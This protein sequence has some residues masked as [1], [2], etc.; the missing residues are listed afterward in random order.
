M[1]C[2][3]H[4]LPVPT[5][6]SL[7]RLPGTC[8]KHFR[9]GFQTSFSALSPTPFKWCS[10]QLPA[11][12]HALPH[13]VPRFKGLIHHA[14]IS[15]PVSITPRTPRQCS[16]TLLPKDERKENTFQIFKTFWVL[17]QTLVFNTAHI[18]HLR[19]T[20]SWEGS[21]LLIVQTRK[22]TQRGH[23]CSV[24]FLMHWSSV[25]ACPFC[26]LLRLCSLPGHLSPIS[27]YL[28]ILP[29]P[30]KMPS[31]LRKIRFPCTL[32]WIPLSL[33]Q[34]LF[35]CHLWYYFLPWLLFAYMP[36]LLS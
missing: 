16:P 4:L 18:S 2:S 25:L 30:C 10:H 26:A 5:A 14:P 12:N 35:I 3:D 28:F 9:S 20:W 21:V 32:E 7:F 36:C 24:L 22:Q 23:I 15:K 1:Y 6:C 29:G 31:P 19:L 27:T 11:P 17:I 34:T 33:H 13:Y 8:T